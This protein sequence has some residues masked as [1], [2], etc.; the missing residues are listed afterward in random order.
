MTPL[1]RLIASYDSRRP[2][3]R[4]ETP[5]KSWYVDPRVAELEQRTV[6]ARTWQFVGRVD[7][8]REPGQYLTADVSGEPVVVVRGRDGALRGFF[9]VC[10][11]HAAIVM[12]QPCGKATALKCPYHGWTYGL[13]GKL[14]SN[15]EFE[16]VCGFEKSQNGLMPLA[17]E[18]WEQFV[19]VRIEPAGPSLREY[20]GDMGEQVAALRLDKLHFVER[21]TWELNCNWKVFVDNY[22]DGGYH[23]PHAHQALGSVLDYARYRIDCFDRFVRQSS[24][25]DSAGGD[26]D[27][28]AT[29]RGDM[30]HYYWLH[31]NFML[32]WYEGYMDINV[33]Y[34]LGVDRCRVL[35]DFFFADAAPASPD[36]ARAVEQ[37]RSIAMAERVQDEDIEVCESV[38]RG[39]SSRAYETG[40]LSV[41]REAGE[42]L[43][44]RLLHRDL[45]SSGAD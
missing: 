35:F 6:F 27:A 33:V 13:E 42:H 31:P 40:R 45:Q 20:L 9:N 18:T 29:R 23:V 11:H 38:Q 8:V 2:L 12:P 24:P 36:D 1:P 3:D 37:A 44:H 15:G 39:L 19:F 17:A 16:E 41:R 21:R 4:A 14:V 30:A 5:P 10:R 28:A 26:A 43:F 34:P 32:N 7:Q 22:L 25:I